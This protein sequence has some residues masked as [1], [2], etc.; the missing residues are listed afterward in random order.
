[1]FGLVH[2]IANISGIALMASLT[3]MV[4]C[5]LPFVRRGGYFEVRIHFINLLKN[6][7]IYKYLSQHTYL[8]KSNHIFPHL[9][10]LGFLF[11]PSSLLCLL[12]FIGTSCTRVLEMVTSSWY[13]IF[14][15][16]DV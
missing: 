2:G 11:H 4:V 6:T 10:S 16:T 1:M 8:S 15:G 12:R 3:I 13:D 5:S 9:T 7:Y 14:T